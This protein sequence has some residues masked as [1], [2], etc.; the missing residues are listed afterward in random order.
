MYTHIVTAMN[1]F[2][3]FPFLTCIVC[4]E[5]NAARFINF[6][7]SFRDWSDPKRVCTCT[8]CRSRNRL[9]KST[10]CLHSFYCRFSLNGGLNLGRF[11]R[12]SRIFGTNSCD[13]THRRCSVQ[14]PSVFH[15]FSSCLQEMG[16][17]ASEILFFL[18]F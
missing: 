12:K 2:A 3:L 9:A 16:T 17:Y 18:K 1:R 7:E 10:M 5:N 14:K 13:L 11:P 8:S 4:V 6:F 15:P